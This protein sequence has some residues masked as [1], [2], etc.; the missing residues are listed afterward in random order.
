MY[1]L[2]YSIIQYVVSKMKLTLQ[3][4]VCF[5]VLIPCDIF[6]DTPGILN[7]N[8][9]NVKRNTMN[10]TNNTIISE[11]DTVKI[12]TAPE[13]KP[14]TVDPATTALLI[15]DIQNQNC[16]LERRPRCV[17]SVPKIKS[18]LEK[19][20]SAG[21]P[22]VYSLTRNAQPSDI[23]KE[24]TPRKDESVVASS[25]DKFY[26]TDLEKILKEKNIKTVII[27]GTSAHGAV[28]HTATGAAM[29]GFTVIVPVDGLSASEPYAE[30]YTCWHLA[31]APGTRRSTTLTRTDLITITTDKTDAD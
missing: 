11:W 4:L 29:H 7:V 26:K 21:V 12:P 13:L 22:V 5:S 30:Q 23:R 15:L 31:N 17:R 27:T 16:N 8:S 1:Y 28:L 14:V 10:S 25:V 3:L 9:N 24:V 18:L 2:Y 20:R 19:A 6:A